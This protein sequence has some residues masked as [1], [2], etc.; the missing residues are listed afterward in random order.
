MSPIRYGTEQLN[1][2]LRFLSADEVAGLLSPAAAAD[3]LARGFLPRTSEEL[4]GVL[5]TVLP[6]TTAGGGEG[7]M[8]LMPAS[9]PEGAGVKLVSIVR[10]N[11]E[12]GLPLIQGV[13]VLLTPDGL[14]PELVVDGA[15]LTRLRTVAVSVLA[16]RYLARPD[17]RRLVVFGAGV[18]AQSHVDA[19]CAMFP[20]EHVTVVGRT[21]ESPSAARLAQ[22]LRQRGLEAHVGEPDAVA[23]ADLI[24]ACTT[25]TAPLFEDADLPA[26]VHINAIGA[27]R[28][29]MLELPAASLGR[30]TLVVESLE[31]T[32]TEA[33][34]VAAAIAEGALPPAHFARE[35]QTLVAGGIGRTRDDE[36]TIFKSVG[37]SVEDLIVA[38]ALADALP[39]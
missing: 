18:Q 6:I 5:R 11:P 12:R 23:G 31:A 27:Y 26:G 34:D 8:L 37:L 28:L 4:D 1:G 29:D 19:M 7:E 14:S 38:R 30:A 32:L 16:T 20:I 2:C 17:S 10:G 22:G 9:G 25:S 39:N 13:Y 3:A 24:C 35:L 36:V 33:G 15:A 21:P